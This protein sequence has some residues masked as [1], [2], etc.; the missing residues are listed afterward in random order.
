MEIFVISADGVLDQR[1]FSH[2][3]QH[4]Q[5]FSLSMTTRYGYV[6]FDSLQLVA[7]IHQQSS[8]IQ[9][10]AD[11]PFRRNCALADTWTKTDFLLHLNTY[12]YIIQHPF[13]WEYL[14]FKLM[15]CWISG[16][17]V[18]ACSTSKHFLYL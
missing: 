10:R 6:T 11:K 8:F 13:Q 18:A 5:T 7:N 4:I 9:S 14:L 16:D 2:C 17:S 12:H 15:G 1:R 3:M